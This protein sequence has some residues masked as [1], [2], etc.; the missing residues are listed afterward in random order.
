VCVCV[1]VYRVCQQAC[2][3]VLA[4][5]FYARRLTKEWKQIEMHT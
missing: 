1:C 2:I 3:V 5:N 4:C